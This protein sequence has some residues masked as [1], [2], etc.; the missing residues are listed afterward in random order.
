MICKVKENNNIQTNEYVVV[1]LASEVEIEEVF[2]PIF[3]A[4]TREID[5]GNGAIIP[6]SDAHT[7]LG[8][9]GDDDLAGN[10][11]HDYIDG[12]AGND[13]DLKIQF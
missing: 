2:Q 13:T 6:D 7:I 10:I 9:T 11:G 12:R 5:F 3:D 8:G 1:T 4:A